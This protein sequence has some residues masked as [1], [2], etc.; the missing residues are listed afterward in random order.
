MRGGKKYSTL[1]LIPTK[2]ASLFMGLGHVFTLSRDDGFQWMGAQHLPALS[3]SDL[4][5]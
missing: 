2:L 5:T 4:Q 3:P 1:V